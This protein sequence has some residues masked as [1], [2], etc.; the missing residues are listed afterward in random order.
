ML[1]CIIWMNWFWK[2]SKYIINNHIQLF[3]LVLQRRIGAERSTYNWAI[4]Q[5]LHVQRDYKTN[6]RLS[7]QPSFETWVRILYEQVLCYPSMDFV[8]LWHMERTYFGAVLRRVLFEKESKQK[9]NFGGLEWLLMVLCM[10]EISATF[11]GYLFHLAL[12]R[13]IYRSYAEAYFLKISQ[14]FWQIFE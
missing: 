6:H 9:W 3:L 2:D 4:K 10:D 14:R 8:F 12:E 11:Y 5:F 7:I 1:H 13:N